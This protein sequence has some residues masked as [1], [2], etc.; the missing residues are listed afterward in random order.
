MHFFQEI[1]LLFVSNSYIADVFKKADIIVWSVKPQIF[2]GA[3]AALAK[4]IAASQFEFPTG[5]SIAHI[6]IMAGITLSNFEQSVGNLMQGTN[7]TFRCFRTMPNIGLRVGCGVAVFCG[8]ADISD[9]EKQ[10]V[11]SFFKPVGLSYE[12]PEHQINAYGSLFGSGIGF[13]SFFTY[14]IE[15]CYQNARNNFHNAKIL[16]SRCS[17][18]LKPCLTGELKWAFHGI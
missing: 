3:I 17:Q 12:V 5:K 14:C 13:V 7:G 9:C 2:P 8:P 16:S 11:H 6:S 10:L 18:L 15:L 4:E 1:K